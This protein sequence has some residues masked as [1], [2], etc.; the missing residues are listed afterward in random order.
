MKNVAD[1]YAL[2]P[3]QQLMLLH[4][5]TAEGT[6]DVLFNQIVYAINGALD[7]DAYHRAWQLVVDRHPALRTIFVWQDGKDPVQVVREQATLPWNALDWRTL[8]APEQEQELDLLLDADRATGF[9]LLQ[10]PLTR[11]SLIRMG[12]QDYRLVWSS[13]HLIIDRWC[14]GIILEELTSTYEAYAASTFPSLAPAP[15]YRD[16]IAW[17]ARQDEDEARAYWREA[18]RGVQVNPLPLKPANP[19]ET[20]D[21]DVIKLSLEGNVWAALRQFAI[22]SNV[23]PSTLVAAAWAIVLASA[24]GADDV[25]FGL[26]VSGRP[27]DLAEVNRTV[28]CFINNVPLRVTLEGDHLLVPWLQQI[29]DQQLS[30]QS[31]DYASLAQIQSWSGLKTKGALFETLL[32]LQAPVQTAEPTGL[33][34]NYIGGGMQTGYAISL[35]AVPGQDSLR[36]TLTYDRRRAAQEMIE[37]MTDALRRVLPA[38]TAEQVPLHDLITQA[39]IDVPQPET[40]YVPDEVKRG[41]QPFVASRTNTEQELAQIWAELLG[42]PRVGVEDKFYDL[43][44]DSIK[45]LQLMTLIEQR[46]GKDVPISLLFG[47]PSIAQMAAAIGKDD[48]RVTRNPVLVPINQEGTRP[49]IFFTHGVYGGLLWLKNL[50]PLLA[51]DQPAYGLQAVGLQPDSEPDYT[52]EAMAARYV[53]ALRHVQPAGPYYLGGFCFGGVLAYEIARQLE[54]LGQSTALLAI[55]DGFPPQVIDEKRAFFDPRRLQIVR[56]SAP[57]WIRDRRGFGRLRLRERIFSASGP[58]SRRDGKSDTMPS[59][60]FDDLRWLRRRR[61]RGPT[62]AYEDQRARCGG[63]CTAVLWW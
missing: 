12:S 50:A 44:G 13:H 7:V 17:L 51:P 39:G 47:D 18:L 10:A 56:Q 45:A 30:Q 8:T 34:M 9:D 23:T 53:E 42:L 49:P 60:A 35:G 19:D 43:G 52:F 41:K 16:F 6:N 15:R 2:S 63:I 5:R 24:A 46:M 62:A 25:L 1:I 58:E 3:M 40:A 33:T 48:V 38:M 29:Q 32:V 20:A 54:L 27:P 4:A 61:S 55:I 22:E 59:A 28:G 26:T 57:Q 11:I 21:L 31:L 36:L 14:I 37:Q